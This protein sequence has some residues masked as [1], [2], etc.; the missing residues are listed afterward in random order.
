MLK[1][2]KQQNKYVVYNKSRPFRQF[3]SYDE[4]QWFVSGSG[5]VKYF[6]H[7]ISS[8]RYVLFNKNKKKNPYD[9]KIFN[10]Y[11]TKEEAEQV[12]SVLLAEHEEEEK[13]EVERVNN[14]ENKQSVEPKKTPKKTKKK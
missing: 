9:W 5:S 12:L 10:T 3:D 13:Q 7:Q 2:R 11:K 6:I 1:I 8:N 14:I 4:A